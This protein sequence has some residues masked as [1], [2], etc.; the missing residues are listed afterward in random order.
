[1]TGFCVTTVFLDDQWH[2]FS[3]FAWLNVLK[4]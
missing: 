4:F 2:F 1:M 3:V